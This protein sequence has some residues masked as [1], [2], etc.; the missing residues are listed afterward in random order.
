MVSELLALVLEYWEA[1]AARQNVGFRCV[2]TTSQGSSTLADGCAV[3]P[4]EAM[5]LLSV[6][7]WL[8]G[9]GWCRVDGDPEAG[10]WEMVATRD[11]QVG[12]RRGGGGFRRAGR[13]WLPD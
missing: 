4:A 13:M 11:I 2:G 7:Y 8:V 5:L 10:D 3:A 6:T 12:R 9:G 1:S